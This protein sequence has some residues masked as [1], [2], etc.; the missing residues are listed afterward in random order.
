MTKWRC[1]GPGLRLAIVNGREVRIERR[2]E[3]QLWL[4]FVNGLRC[5]GTFPTLK[6]AKAHLRT[7]GVAS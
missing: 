5:G 3:D 7:T 4:A 2:R 6:A 1:P